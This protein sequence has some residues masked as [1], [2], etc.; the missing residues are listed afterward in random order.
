MVV[1]KYTFFFLA[2][3]VNDGTEA[4]PPPPGRCLRRVLEKLNMTVQENAFIFMFVGIDD[5]TE[6]FCA[7]RLPKPHIRGTSSVQFSP[8]TNWV[9][10]RGGGG[11]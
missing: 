7:V 6:T 2:V 8:P 11:A 10:G 3:V 1:E 4:S 9:V 5:G